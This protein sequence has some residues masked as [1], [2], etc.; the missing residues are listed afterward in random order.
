MNFPNRRFIMS[1][2]VT[3]RIRRATGGKIQKKG[4]TNIQVRLS[5]IPDSPPLYVAA[6]TPI[7]WLALV[8]P[9]KPVPISIQ[10]PILRFPSKKPPASLIRRIAH[11]AMTNIAAA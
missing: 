9:A 1:T 8:P 10:R 11:A 3:T 4:V 7:G 2:M 6:A 5:H